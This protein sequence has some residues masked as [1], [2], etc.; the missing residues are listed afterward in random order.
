MLL[1]HLALGYPL[2]AL[3]GT[4]LV[5]LDLWGAAMAAAGL[6]LTYWTARVLLP[7]GQALWT[8]VLV[9]LIPSFPST[10]ATF[11]TDTT[12]FALAM[13]CLGV[14]LRSLVGDRVR[15]GLLAL[16]LGLGVMAFATRELSIVAP[17]GVVVGAFVAERRAGKWPRVSAFALLGLVGAA[18]AL[19]FV[20]HSF[21]D[22]AYS[23]D[24]LTTS[25]GMVTIAQLL[26]T[27]SLAVLPAAMLLQVRSGKGL[28]PG[29]TAVVGFAAVAVLLQSGGLNTCCFNSPPSLFMG[30]LLSHGGPLGNS[31]LAGARP[32]VL[33]QA[34]WYGLMAAAF[35]S[36]AVLAGR[37]WQLFRAP[38]PLARLVRPQ[39]ADP[40]RSVLVVCSTLSIAALMGRVATG[41]PIFDRYLWLPAFGVAVLLF[42]AASKGARAKPEEMRAA[43]WATVALAV[44]S[45]IV[46]TNGQSFDAAALAGGRILGRSRLLCHGHRCRFRMGG[47]PLSDRGAR[48]HRATVHLPGP[49]VHGPF[50]PSRELRVRHSIAIRRRRLGASRRSRVSTVP[51]LDLRALVDLPPGSG[52]HRS[53]FPALTGTIHEWR[54]QADPSTPPRFRRRPPRPSSTTHWRGFPFSGLCVAGALIRVTFATRTPS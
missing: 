16:S 53:R 17:I 13:G 2:A 35:W 34:V 48:T 28:H 9:G 44:V 42:E 29:A 39:R 54:R 10:A 49:W 6:G 5:A 30:N 12:A 52:L 46:V 25:A 23:F 32:P 37:A 36:A 19:Y 8:T 24:P 40:R 27:L 26:F 31:V 41:G 1:G 50:P 45:A 11:M 21:P 38:G 43:A 33:P 22:A 18:V 15:T 47:L 3:T 7:H 4:S 51:R 14:G 20:R